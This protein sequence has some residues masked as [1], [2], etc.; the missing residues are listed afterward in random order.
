M[1]I[2]LEDH[3]AWMYEVRAHSQVAPFF[4]AP[5]PASFQEHARFLKKFIGSGD[6]EFFIILMGDTKCGYCQ[7]IHR[8]QDYEVGFA[9]HPD[10]WGMGIGEMSAKWLIDHIKDHYAPKDI[11]L[12]VKVGNHRA[13]R[14]YTK[15]GFY[16]EKQEGDRCF[17]RKS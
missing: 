1:D 11:V 5:P 8:D 15:L 16:L 3:V 2:N 17:M 4:F 10:W 13:M 9:L 7:I 12:Y 14:L 6:R